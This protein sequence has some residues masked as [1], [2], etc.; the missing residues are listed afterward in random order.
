M[1][2]STDRLVAAARL[3]GPG[4]APWLQPLR[5]WPRIAVH[6]LQRQ[7]VVARIVMASVQGST[8]REA[9]VCMLVSADSIHGTVG[10]G[11]LEWQVET[12]PLPSVPT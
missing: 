12:E 8:P 9:G 6:I 4:D 11:Q 7:P 3:E 1:S 2:V 5:D 10:G